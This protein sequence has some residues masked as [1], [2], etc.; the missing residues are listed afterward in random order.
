MVEQYP[1]T[2]TYSIPGTPDTWD[3]ENG[4]WIPGEPGTITSVECRAGPS[5][6]GKTI[7]GVDGE[8]VS[9]AFDLAFPQGTDAINPG[10]EL[11]ITRLNGEQLITGRLLRFQT[12][13]LHSRG[14]I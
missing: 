2:C 4:G 12:G 6:A 9:Y 11:T 3:E 8:Y 10:T 14:W 13:Q 5:G 7:Q 1:H